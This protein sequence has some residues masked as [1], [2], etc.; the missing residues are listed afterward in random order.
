[1]EGTKE[2]KEVLDF[3]I[4]LAVAIE[5]AGEDGMVSLSD[6]LLFVP[7]II[8][9]PAAFG[10]AAKIPAELT[11]LDDGE[12]AA[13]VAYAKASLDLADDGL[14]EKLEMALEIGLNLAKLVASLK[15]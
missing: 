2:I 15:K 13:L 12:K 5:K 6:A 11:D 14:E 4:P 3:V 7:A 1:M 10:D 8:K 9:A